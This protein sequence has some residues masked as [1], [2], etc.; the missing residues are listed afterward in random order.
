MSAEEG[1]SVVWVVL[2]PAFQVVLLC[3]GADAAEVVDDWAKRGYRIEQLTADEV[4]AA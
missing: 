3:S 1:Q 2:D 4:F